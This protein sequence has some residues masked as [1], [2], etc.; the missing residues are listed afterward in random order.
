MSTGVILTRC[1]PTDTICW[2]NVGLNQH[3]FNILCLPGKM[4]GSENHWIIQTTIP[5]CE[6]APITS[7]I[8]GWWKVSA[9][10]HNKKKTSLQ[11][12]INILVVF[13]KDDH[14]CPRNII[15]FH[16]FIF[17]QVATI[18]HNEVKWTWFRSEPLIKYYIMSLLIYP[19][20]YQLPRHASP[21]KK[22]LYLVFW[23]NILTD[24]S[25]R[26][27]AILTGR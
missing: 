1:S 25:S 10:T 4:S 12:K 13:L 21:Q 2:I 24:K 27:A 3:W 9:R 18:L 16:T 19:C 15:F 22:R 23:H 11:Y 17:E 14:Y 7:G 26:S 8:A 5:Y 6:V 20:Y